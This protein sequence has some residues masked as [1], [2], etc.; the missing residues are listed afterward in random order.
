MPKY[1]FTDYAEDVLKSVDKPLIYQEIWQQ[2]VEQDIVERLSSSGKTP[3]Q[4]LGAR[5]F[6]D[7]RDNPNTR[8]I[9]I[10]KNP[11]KFFLKSRQ[12]E[13]TPEMLKLIEEDREEKPLHKEQFLF[14]ERDLHPLVAYFA[15]SNPSFKRGKQIYTRTILH[16][17]S[18]HYSPSEWA[19]PDMVGFYLPIDDI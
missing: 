3:W 8:F 2:G 14:H 18:H 17:K 9:K 7:V 19:Y 6:V 10:S 5:L 4:T 16:E 12:N 13:L 1:T 11:A 15:Y